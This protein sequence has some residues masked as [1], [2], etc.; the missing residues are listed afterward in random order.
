V[1]G[2]PGVFSDSALGQVYTVHPSNSQCF[3]LRL[4]LHHVPG[5]VSFQ[6]LR[7]VSGHC[8]ATFHEAC[9]MGGL[10]EGDQLWHLTLQEAAAT[11]SAI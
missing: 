4:L 9:Q 8:C 7:T 5:P 1:P 11:R 6:Y 3:Y 2:H 10:L